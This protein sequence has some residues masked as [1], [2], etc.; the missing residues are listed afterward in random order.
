[1]K[2]NDLGIRALSPSSLAVW[3]EAGAYWAVRYAFG[4]KDNTGASQ[5][6]GTAVEA[7]LVHYLHEKSDVTTLQAIAQANF[8]QNLAG[9]IGDWVDE[10]RGLINSM[11]NVMIENLKDVNLPRPIGSQIRVETYL[12]GIEIPF[13]GYVDIVFDRPLPLWE[14]K[15]TKRM[16]SEPRISHLRQVSLY[17]YARDM[18]D[19]KIIYI[20]D[21][22]YKE[23]S[24]DNE[25]VKAQI[26]GMREDAKSLIAF[27]S[28][29]KSKQDML[30]VLPVNESSFYWSKAS[31]EFR[32]KC[33]EGEIR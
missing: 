22:R 5:A 4:W 8:D 19:G 3:R 21:K 12:D 9:E 15:T 25:T 10:E 27:L 32:R 13:M 31:L 29:I 23:F 28:M 20:T 2:L 26:N 33:I 30:K 16:P 17:R 24:V 6:R 1:M 18:Q 14:L 7:A 11:I